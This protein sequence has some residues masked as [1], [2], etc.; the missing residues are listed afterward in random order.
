MQDFQS[1]RSVGHLTQSLREMFTTLSGKWR[2]T[3]LEGLQCFIAGA[4]LEGR[5]RP[6]PPRN[7]RRKRGEKKEKKKNRLKMYSKHIFL[8]GLGEASSRNNLY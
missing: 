8:Q 1:M 7:E 6:S 3:Y 4:D 5:A 2:E